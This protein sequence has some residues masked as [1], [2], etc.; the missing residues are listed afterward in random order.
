M[1]GELQD[2][3]V[4]PTLPHNRQELF[5]ILTGGDSPEL[6]AALSSSLMQNMRIFSSRI[7]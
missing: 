4:I 5:G 1:T 6:S 3:A 2:E 7:T